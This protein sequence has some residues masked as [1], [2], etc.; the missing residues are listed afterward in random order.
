MKR[1]AVAALV[2]VG[3]VPSA[4]AGG[5]AP[6]SAVEWRLGGGLT[7]M[8][9]D[10]TSLAPIAGTRVDLGFASHPLARSPGGRYL[11]ATG[12][13]VVRVID[14]KTRKG[15]RPYSPAAWLSE[16]LWTRAD[17]VVGVSSEELVLFDPKGPR[18]RRRVDLGGAVLASGK[19]GARLVLLI[20]PADGIGA[21]RV[22]VADGNGAVRSTPIAMR[23]GHRTLR[24]EERNPIG[25]YAETPGL[26]VDAA[27]KRA[28][29]AGRTS[30]VEV[31]LGSLETAAHALAIRT[32]Q[33]SI[34]GWSRQAV[35][36]DRD[37]VA[38][39][40]SEYEAERSPTP[41]PVRIVDVRDW[42]ALE[43]DAKT[44]YVVAWQSRLLTVGDSLRAYDPTGKL[45]HT[46]LE[47][48]FAGQ[49][50][51]GETWLYVETTGRGKSWRVLD[52]NGRVMGTHTFARPTNIIE[53][54]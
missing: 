27:G 29:V 6:I 40:G 3:L 38:V 11:F 46:L 48:R 37:H 47:D 16:A 44:S 5:P 52:W 35:W 9:L 39:A 12:G 53:I 49:V 32:A 34:E 33:K 18:V 10:A 54:D 31:D 15:T 26:A 22:A 23:G 8:K 4:G 17:T 41:A 1:F 43:I 50:I 28:V 45:V 25:M 2:L 42:S 14:L 20:A 7:L 13:N 19:A 30:I 21:L 51:P 24:D 36:L